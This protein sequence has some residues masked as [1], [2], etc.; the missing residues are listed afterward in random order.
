LFVRINPLDTEA[1]DADL[2]EIAHRAPDG[3]VLPKA[4]GA[5]AVIELGRRLDLLHCVQRPV[6]PIAAE[7]P[8]S[9]F[10]LSQYREVAGRLAG[11]TWGAEDLPRSI[12]AAESRLPGGGFTPVFEMVRSLT[13]F[14]AHAAGVA[15][16]EA[17]YPAFKDLE[18]LAHFAARAARDGFN[19]MLAIHPSQVPLINAAFT[20]SAEALERA[21]NIVAAFQSR[22]GVGSIDFSGVML[23]AAHLKH[24]E[25]VIARGADHNK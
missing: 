4:D 3:Y 8:S 18:G 14:A 11:L 1:A 15:A 24:A 12:D 20:P 13:L 22:P 10:T 6:L 7:T 16:I 2:R 17:V 23:D 21:R 19:G 25:R 5:A 9:V